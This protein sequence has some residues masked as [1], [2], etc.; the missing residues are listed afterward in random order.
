MAKEKN[1]VDLTD[2]G[3][4]RIQKNKRPPPP[5]GEIFAKNISV[6]KKR[7]SGKTPPGGE[8]WGV[9]GKPLAQKLIF[10]FPGFPGCG[11]S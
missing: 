3:K 8:E 7:E 2:L 10:Q 6:S 5:G 1:C 4:Q 11:V 9:K